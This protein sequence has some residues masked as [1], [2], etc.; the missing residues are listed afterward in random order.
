M[1]RMSSRYYSVDKKGLHF[2]LQFI[3]LFV[4]LAGVTYYD[5][6]LGASYLEKNT[7]GYALHADNLAQTPSTAAAAFASTTPQRVINRLTIADAVPTSGKFIAADLV[8]MKILLYQDGAQMGEYVI[9]SKGRPGTPWETPSGFY[10]IQTKEKSH[11]SS[12]GRVYMPYSMQFYGNYFI[13]GWTYY[14]D[15]TPTASTFSGGCIKL[16][17]VDAEAIF[18]FADVGTK[19]FVY[20]SVHSELPPALYLDTS[21]TLP[22]LSAATYLVADIDTG[23][24]YAEQD[25]SAPRA[26][27]STTK[28]MTALVANEVLSFDKKIT[29]PEGALAHPPVA[30]ATSTKTFLVGDLL[31]PLLMQSND[32]VAETLASYYSTKSFVRWMNTTAQALGMQATTFADPSGVSPDNVSTA[33]DLF[34]L[35]VYLSHKKSFVLKI[36]TTKEKNIVADDAA[37]YRIQNIHLSEAASTTLSVLSLKVDNETR[38]VAVIVFESPD[39]VGDLKQLTH[40]ITTAAKESANLTACASCTEPTYRMIEL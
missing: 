33:E 16:E 14:P 21:V 29:I 37:E 11:F 35:A 20:D 31:Y 38:R 34:R 40:W 32:R 24:V 7:G 10:N 28:L 22:R 5:T 8:N 3:F 25:T 30:E 1:E 36:A 19:V 27:A 23:D 17:T 9:K 26:L 6:L 2:S 12:I 18:A 39:Q 13:H 4:L 15:G